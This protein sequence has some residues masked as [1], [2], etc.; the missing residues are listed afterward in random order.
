MLIGPFIKNIISKEA[1]TK[2]LPIAK[3]ILIGASKIAAQEASRTMGEKTVEVLAKGP[4]KVENFVDKKK[5]EYIE[6]AE[7]K[8]EQFFA[9]QLKILE[10]KIEKKIDDV[11]KRVDEKIRAVFWLF[12]PSMFV[13]VI[14]SGLVLSLLF[15]YFKI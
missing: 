2:A 14:L 11:E 10:E 5:N 13:V 1:M 4:K 7:L 12:L 3:K 15:K 6:E 8:A 9:E